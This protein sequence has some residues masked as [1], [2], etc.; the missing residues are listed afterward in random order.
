MPED[1]QRGLKY[2]NDRVMSAMTAQLA[3]KQKCHA[4]KRGGLSKYVYV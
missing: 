2:E 1:M 3:N 4:A